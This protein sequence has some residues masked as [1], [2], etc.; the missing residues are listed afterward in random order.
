M[1]ADADLSELPGEGCVDRRGFDVGRRDPPVASMLLWIPELSEVFA[2]FCTG[3]GSRRKLTQ[4]AAL[5]EGYKL[6]CHSSRPMPH[7]PLPPAS[8]TEDVARN[9]KVGHSYPRRWLLLLFLGSL[10]SDLRQ[11]VGHGLSCR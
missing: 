3:K 1:A 6:A 10:S 8:K 5:M 2:G 9:M 7:L 4:S 11:L